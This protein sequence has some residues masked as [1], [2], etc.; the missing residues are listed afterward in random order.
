MKNGKMSLRMGLRGVAGHGGTG[1]RKGQEGLVCARLTRSQQASNLRIGMSIARRIPV[2]V[3]ALALAA[4]G[5]DCPQASTP[6]E[7]MQC[8]DTMGCASQG[9]DGSQDCCKTM[10]AIHAPFVKQSS[11]QA[12]HLSPRLCAGMPP[13][14]GSQSIELAAETLLSPHSHAPPISP[15]TFLSPLRI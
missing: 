9:H 7:A 10:Q 12:S 13:V 15:P 11:S 2:L 4:Y 14:S 1:K 8:C 3:F 6:D 5:F